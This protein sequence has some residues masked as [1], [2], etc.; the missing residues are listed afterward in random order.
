[1]GH[2][3]IRN[4]AGTRGASDHNFKVCNR[5]GIF[6]LLMIESLRYTGPFGRPELMTLL[7]RPNLELLRR[8]YAIGW[9]LDSAIVQLVL[10]FFGSFAGTLAYHTAILLRQEVRMGTTSMIETTC[11]F[12]LVTA[13]DLEVSSSSKE[14]P[15]R[16]SKALISE[17]PL[18]RE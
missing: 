15:M 4:E 8:E 7:L 1:M 9:G 3:N 11:N 13:G 10:P 14:V 18:Y 2:L 12:Q 6:Y 5:E 17:S 16:S